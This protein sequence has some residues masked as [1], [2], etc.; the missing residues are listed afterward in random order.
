MYT[1]PLLLGF[2][3]SSTVVFHSIRQGLWHVT[4]QPKFWFQHSQNLAVTRPEIRQYSAAGR[5]IILCWDSDHQTVPAL[6]KIARYYRYLSAIL[7]AAWRVTAELNEILQYFLPPDLMHHW[8]VFKM[9]RFV[10]IFLTRMY[11]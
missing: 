10:H 4:A 7:K 11:F 3:F 9:I 6:E 1:A 5:K 2:K 8:V